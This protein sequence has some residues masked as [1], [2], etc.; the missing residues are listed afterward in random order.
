MENCIFCRI[1]KGE[2]ESN[3][4]YKGENVIGIEDKFPQAPKHYLLV[5]K[6]H[7]QDI[8]NLTDDDDETITEMYRAVKKIAEE[9]KLTD[10]GFRTVINQG[11][12][13]GQTIYHLHMHIMGGR[14]MSWPPG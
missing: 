6:K 1:V 13:G 10:L 11:V 3:Y 7:I 12:H 5:S 8:T 2:I 9:K 4:V 14:R